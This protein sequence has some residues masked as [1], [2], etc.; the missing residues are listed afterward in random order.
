[1]ALYDVRCKD[2][3]RY[4]STGAKALAEIRER[5]N[6]LYPGLRAEGTWILDILCKWNSLVTEENGTFKLSEL[7]RAFISLPGREGEEITTEEKVFLVG[8]MM[9]DEDQRQVI[10]GHPITDNFVD[11]QTRRCLEKMGFL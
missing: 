11:G 10:L 7:G 3:A 8:V 5:I 6:Q 2:V 4:L 9:L 1:M